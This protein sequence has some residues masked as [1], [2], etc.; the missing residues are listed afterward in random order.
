MAEVKPERYRYDEPLA[1]YTSFRI[2]GPADLLVEVNTRAE[3]ANLISYCERAGI[4]WFFLGRGSNVLVDD[5]GFRGVVLRFGPDFAR[6]KVEGTCLRAGA[7]AP[8]ALVAEAAARHSLSGLEFASGIPGSLGGGIYMNA[9]S[10][11]GEMKDVVISAEVYRPRTGFTILSREELKF[12]Y[13][14]SVLQELG[15]ILVE[16]LLQ[17]TPGD[18]AVIRNRMKE[19]NAQRRAKQPLEYPSAGSVFKRP[20]GAFAG[21]LIEEAGLKGYRIGQAQVSPKHAGFIVNLGGATARDVLA[22]I[23]EVQTVVFERTGYRLEPEIR[24]LCRE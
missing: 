2:G 18:E 20:E 9:G 6:I 17:L 24:I 8:L 16:A 21:K 22:L 15:G 4:P 1:G 13:R 14:S 3:L 7:A 12:G 23:K 11:G 5:A 19:L 10:Y